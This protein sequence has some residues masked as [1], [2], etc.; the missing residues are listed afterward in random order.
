MKHLIIFA[1]R[2]QL[3]R[4]KT[5]LAKDIGVVAAYRFYENT[6]LG[7]TRSLSS[8]KRW[9]T[10]LAI[11]PNHTRWNNP[12]V[13]KQISQMPQG[14]GSLGERMFRCISRFENSPAIIIGSDIPA[15]KKKHIS[16]AFKA[17]QRSD[18]VFGPS[19][20]GG[21]WLVGAAKG[22][23][24]QILFNNIDWSS[25]RVLTQTLGNI[26]TKFRVIFLEKLIDVDD[27]E[28]YNSWRQATKIT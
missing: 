4:V 17:L 12:F 25:D 2:P 21:Y 23:A 7:L 20:D 3:G 14:K 19:Y 1:R 5:R 10:W 16:N 24:A 9:K 6:L 22:C 27:G 11:T 28:T 8:D 13:L 26:P 15:I 18:F